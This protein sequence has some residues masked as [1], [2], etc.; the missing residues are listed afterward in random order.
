MPLRPDW[1]INRIGETHMAEVSDEATTG[2]FTKCK[3]EAHKYPHNGNDAHGRET[4]HDHVQDV[5]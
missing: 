4:H 2:I 3:R 1:L 5:L